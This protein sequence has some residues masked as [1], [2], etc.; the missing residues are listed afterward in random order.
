MT[1]RLG[2]FYF[3][4]HSYMA[5]LVNTLDRSYNG[6]NKGETVEITDKATIKD[7]LENG[8][9]YAEETAKN[10]GGDGDDQKPQYLKFT[11][12]ADLAGWAKLEENGAVVLDETKTLKEMVADYEAAL[13]AKNTGGDGDP[14]AQ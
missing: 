3:L 4:K 11:K 9:E 8:F 2:A 1:Y 5:T 6:I 14:A 13:A 12:K 10:T 7:Y